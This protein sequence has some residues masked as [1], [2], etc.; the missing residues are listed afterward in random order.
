[1]PKDPDVC[2]SGGDPGD[3]AVYALGRAEW[4][5]MS[6]DLKGSTAGKR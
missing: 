3:L 6:F 5:F 4:V 1:M 2:S